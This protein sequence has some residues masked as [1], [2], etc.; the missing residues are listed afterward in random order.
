M[1]RRLA[2]GLVIMAA[3]AAGVQ[4]LG[5]ASGAPGAR[6]S[7]PLPP[8]PRFALAIP[9]PERLR[10]AG[11]A[12]WTVVRRR[13]VARAAPTRRARPV[14]SVTRR[15]PEGTPNA[16]L[17]LGHR[18]EAGGRV[19]VRA[20]LPVL[21]N[22]TVGWIPR[23]A[24]GGYQIVRTRLVVDLR[25]RTAT[26]LRRDRA[27]FRAPAGVG[28]PRWPTPRGEFYIRNRLTRYRSPTY[29]PLA[30]GTSAR[31]THLT[32]WP[33]GGY[34]GIHGTDRPELLPGRVSHGC[35][36][37]RN[38][39]ILRLGRLMPVGTPVTIR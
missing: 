2:A 12:V 31:S 37:L 29:G 3:V 20:R 13:A 33:A 14:A 8:P 23:R 25:A 32:D 7:D 30:F 24:L 15:T 17:V 10:T 34:I 5:G 18:E 28:Q 26:L 22:G 19:W 11:S 4:L 21:P 39:D 16:V 1:R 27:V 36:R 35:I 9:P 6:R 38:R